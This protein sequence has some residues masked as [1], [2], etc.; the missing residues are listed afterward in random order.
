MAY[1]D[2]GKT[3][4][5]EAI[6]LCL[7]AIGEQPI[8]AVPTSGTS[9]ATIARDLVYEQSRD[10]QLEGLQCNTENKYLIELDED[11]YATLP[12]NTLNVDT[13]YL[14]QNHLVERAGKLYDTK[15]Q[16]FVL[17][18]DVY[19]DLILFLEW[20]DLPQHVRR[21]AGI[22]AARL[23]QKRYISDEKAH[24]FTEEDELKAKRQFQRKEMN[25]TDVS[26]FDNPYLNRGVRR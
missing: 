23:F 25:N 18:D 8:N 21:Y 14:Y 19:V 4:E 24:R 6:N 7:G 17:T 1:G 15:E 22:Q 9:K 2:F 5:L 26:I 16:T 12:S 20:T 13:S 10:V 3:T 11:S